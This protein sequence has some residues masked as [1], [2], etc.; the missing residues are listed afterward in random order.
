MFGGCY[1]PNKCSVAL[2][3]IIMLYWFPLES[4]CHMGKGNVVDISSKRW[5]S[6]LSWR[7]VN[8]RLDN[9]K[10][11]GQTAKKTSI[12]YWISRR[13]FF[14]RI[15]ILRSLFL[16]W[17]AEKVVLANISRS[18]VYQSAVYSFA[19]SRCACLLRRHKTSAR[20]DAFM[21]ITNAIAEVPMNLLSFTHYF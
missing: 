10:V 9:S 8:T 19:I 12:S 5:N 1:A 15:L 18:L 13:I 6:Y 3:D 14:C 4:V 7:R 20:V 21:V 16:Y 17:A 2:P 11:Y